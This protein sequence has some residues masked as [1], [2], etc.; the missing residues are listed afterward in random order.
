MHPGIKGDRGPSSIDWAIMENS[1]E[2]GVTALEADAET[3]AGDI[4]SKWAGG[5]SIR[6]MSV[7]RSKFHGARDSIS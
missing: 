3:D 4:W 5:P 1:R 2:W 6:E 7:N